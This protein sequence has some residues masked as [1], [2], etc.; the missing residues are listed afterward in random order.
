M[1]AA[2]K[3]VSPKSSTP[4]RF[5]FVKYLIHYFSKDLSNLIFPNIGLILSVTLNCFSHK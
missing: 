3:E 4:I 2:G 5:S 1:T